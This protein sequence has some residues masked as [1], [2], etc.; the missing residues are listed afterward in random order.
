MQKFPHLFSPIVIAGHTYKNRII[1]APMLFGFYALEKESAERVYAIVDDRS[2]GGAA[3]VV[4]GETPINYD[5]AADAMLLFIRTDYTKYSGVQFDAYRKYANI[6]RNNG[7]IPLIEIFHS[8]FQRPR[9][10]NGINPWG[11]V[12]Y[13]RPDGV[14]VEAFR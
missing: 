11:P 1:T 12:G 4:V 5:D 13:T 10:A 9:P 6:I 3:A 8:G 7:A 14:V 2:R